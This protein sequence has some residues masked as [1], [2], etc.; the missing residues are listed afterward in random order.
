MGEDGLKLLREVGDKYG[1]PVVT[2]VTDPRCVEGRQ[3]PMIPVSE[4]AELRA[5]DG[6]RQN[7]AA[8]AAQTR[9]SAT[10]QTY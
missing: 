10:V 8:G 7:E 3:T 2:E 4:H 1:M 9:M 5:T 6:S